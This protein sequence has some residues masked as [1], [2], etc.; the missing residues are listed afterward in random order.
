MAA[1]L[2]YNSKSSAAAPPG[3]GKGGECATPD[4]AA[5]L[6]ALPRIAKDWRKVLSNFAAAV[7][8]F[9]VTPGHLL[10]AAEVAGVGD[11]M[12]THLG[13]L[14]RDLRWAFPT[15]EHAFQGVKCLPKVD[16]FTATGP[17]GVAGRAAP[18]F[19]AAGA[20]AQ[21]ARKAVLL[22]PEGVA[23]WARV[24]HVVMQVAMQARAS[25]DPLFRQV[26]V[27]T[28]DAEL[29]HGT[30]GVPPVRMVGLEAVRRQVRGASGVGGGASAGAGSGLAP[31]TSRKRPRTIPDDAD[32]EDF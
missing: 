4:Q 23:R 24:S 14:P 1:R 13:S 10:D 27:A 31:S 20:P 2:F 18:V 32:D 25:V 6:A 28:G 12:R 3:A 11:A 8:D 30:R 29:W 5:E 17:I 7:V 15:V 9:V 26:L 16:D 19:T 22:T 21:K